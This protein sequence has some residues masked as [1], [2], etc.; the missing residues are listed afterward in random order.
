MYVELKISKGLNEW[1]CKDIDVDNVEPV[2][3]SLWK[4]NAQKNWQVL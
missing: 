4:N 3:K 1:M 2:L